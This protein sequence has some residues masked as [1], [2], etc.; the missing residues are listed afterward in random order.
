[1][2]KLED[3]FK[4]EL[5]TAE[6]IMS[7]AEMLNLINSTLITSDPAID[8]KVNDT[9]SG[10]TILIPFVVEDLYSEPTIMDDSNTLIPTSKI[11]KDQIFARINF[12]AK[13]WAEKTLAKIKGSGINTI[14]AARSFLGNYWSKDLQAKM[15]ALTTGAIADNKANH[16]SDNVL[17][18][19]SKFNYSNA[20][21]ALV[22]AGEHLEDFA[23][24]GL[25][26]LTYAEILKNDAA[27]VTTV[28]D[29]DLGIS[30]KFY[31][32]LEIIVSDQ[33]PLVGA[34]KIT[35]VFYRKGA[36]VYSNA[37][38][39][40]PVETFRDP[41]QGNGAGEDQIISRNGF[42]LS[43]NGYS[44]TSTNV[45]GESVTNA[46]MADPANQE[47]KVDSKLAPFVALETLK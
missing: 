14:D 40:N 2:T 6:D 3:Y 37:N 36:F 43:L 34:D 7:S 20:V 28:K 32:G 24:I 39:E 16:A 30:K 15:I 11:T 35:T 19:D 25:H 47:R 42:L 4:R 23:A 18:V 33:F 21:D 8:K 44:F 9:D 13:S 22:L 38:L 27:S 46:E 5:W 17:T 31:N 45:A 29:S 26:S 10:D 12:Y 41:R 1:M